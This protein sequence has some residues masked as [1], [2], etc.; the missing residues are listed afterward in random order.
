MTKDKPIEAQFCENGGSVATLRPSLQVA[1]DRRLRRRQD[2]HPLQLLR[3][4]ILQLHL[5]AHLWDR[6]QDQNDKLPWEED[7]ASVLGHRWP[8]KVL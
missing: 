1:L 6:L 2:Q 5:H 8:G 3:G 7:Q 4:G